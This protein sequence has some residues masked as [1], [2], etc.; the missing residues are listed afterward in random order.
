M[1]GTKK[2]SRALLTMWECLPSQTSRLLTLIQ[3]KSGTTAGECAPLKPSLNRSIAKSCKLAT[4]GRQNSM[5]DIQLADM[6]MGSHTGG[7]WIRQTPHQITRSVALHFGK[8][9]DF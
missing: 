9:G 2:F 6:T 1:L 3:C 8:L 5:L 4:P 7:I